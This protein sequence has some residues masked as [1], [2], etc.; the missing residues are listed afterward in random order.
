MVVCLPSLCR[1]P[2]D[3]YTVTVPVS[4]QVDTP[5]SVSALFLLFYFFQKK[6]CFILSV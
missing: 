3:V 4:A 1:L 2:L 5:V 6:I